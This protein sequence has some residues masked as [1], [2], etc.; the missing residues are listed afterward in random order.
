MRRE[1][2][3]PLPHSYNWEIKKYSMS[4]TTA[5]H[6]TRILTMVSLSVLLFLSACAGGTNQ[7]EVNRQSELLTNRQAELAVQPGVAKA[8]PA[9]AGTDGGSTLPL[10]K[11]AAPQNPAQQD[12]A[13][14]Q[15]AV[16]LQDVSEQAGQLPAAPAVD[17]SA[18][19]QPVTV[20]QSLPVEPRVGARAPQFNL[21]T[22]DGQALNMDSL[23]GHPVVISYWATWCIPC[24]QELP[25]LQKL[26]QEY[27]GSG[28]IVLTVNAIDQDSLDKVQA[29]LAEKGMNLPVLLDEGS[30]FAN[31]Y[32]AMFFP[33]TYYIDPAGVIRFIKLGDSTEEDLRSH[34]DSLMKGEL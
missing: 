28:L 21:T 8:A 5:Q 2:V 23:L 17:L 32:Q 31:D 30:T 26:Y 33:T 6:H 10:A 24:Q 20:D 29:M 11:G 18:P 7:V 3:Q 12:P 27:A 13:W 9:I 16:S 22:I 19:A 4:K 14:S 25:I 34:V 15:P 1:D